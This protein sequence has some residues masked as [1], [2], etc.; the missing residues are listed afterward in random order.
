MDEIFSTGQPG[1]ICFTG[2]FDTIF[3]IIYYAGK[4]V[5]MMANNYD[6]FNTYDKIL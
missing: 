4:N 5:N 1:G 3:V 2:L 6:F